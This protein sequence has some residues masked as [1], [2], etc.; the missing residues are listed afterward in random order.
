MTI[1]NLITTI[2]NRA[3]DI[4]SQIYEFVIFGVIFDPSFNSAKV[5]H[6]TYHTRL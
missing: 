1:F 4:G 2:N 5:K 6:I 3:V